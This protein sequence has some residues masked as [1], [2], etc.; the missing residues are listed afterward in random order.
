MPAPPAKRPTHQIFILATLRLQVYVPLGS[1]TKEVKMWIAAFVCFVLS[2]LNAQSLKDIRDRSNKK[3]GLEKFLRDAQRAPEPYSA[4]GIFT[5]EDIQPLFEGRE[6]EPHPEEPPDTEPHPNDH[7]AS[8]ASR[9]FHR[10]RKRYE[11]E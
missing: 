3:S 7:T 4:R 2:A 8:M 5:H 6:Y 1:S 11:A 10:F 9:V